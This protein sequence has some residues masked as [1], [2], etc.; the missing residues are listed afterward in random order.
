MHE[1]GIAAGAGHDTVID[2]VAGKGPFALFLLF[3]LAHAGP[4]VGDHQVH[5]GGGFPWVAD[6]PAA[7]SR[8]LEDLLLR[9]IAF[10]AGDMQLKAELTRGIDIGVAHIVAVTDPGHGTSLDIPPVLQVGLHVREQL[11]GVQQVGQAVDHRYPGVGGK[12]LHLVVLE[13]ADHDAVHHPGQ[14]PGAVFDRLA[15]P[16]LGIP[17]RQEQG[18]T[19]QLGH[20]G[21]EGDP[22]AGGGLFEHHGQ[23]TAIERLVALAGTQNLFQLH[24]PS[25]QSLQR[26]RS[27][28]E[29]GEKVPGVGMFVHNVLVAGVAV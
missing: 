29:Q 13:G 17:R 6:D 9:L 3:L 2:L 5:V 12:A 4:D 16:Q 7:C 24:G 19:A 10:R 28:V 26:L 15:T 25:Q 20:A 11:T 14:Y 22:G 21:L 23:G 1:Q 18:M 27:Q 8:G